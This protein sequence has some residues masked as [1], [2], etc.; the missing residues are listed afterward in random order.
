MGVLYTRVFIHKMKQFE[1]NSE[2]EPELF[3]LAN[4]CRERLDVSTRDF[5][6]HVERRAP[7]NPENVAMIRGLQYLCISYNIK[8]YFCFVC[9]LAIVRLLR[10]DCFLSVQPRVSGSLSCPFLNKISLNIAGFSMCGFIKFWSAILVHCFFSSKK[11]CTVGTISI[12]SAITKATQ[13]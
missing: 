7:I 9:F 1:W 12:V 2:S 6:I 11:Y 5:N 3:L 13:I 8:L 10:Y 4:L